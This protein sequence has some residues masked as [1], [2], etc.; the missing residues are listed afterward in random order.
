MIELAAAR[1]GIPFEKEMQWLVA[2]D[3]I[4]SGK[5]DSALEHVPGP[6]GALRPERLDALVIAIDST[7]AVRDLAQRARLSAQCHPRRVAVACSARSPQQILRP[8]PRPG[9]TAP[10]RN[11]GSSCRGTARPSGAHIRSAAEPDR[12]SWSAV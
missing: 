6:Q 3:P 2:D 9:A 4:V 12:G 1:L 10:C 7:P 11:R 5:G 8:A